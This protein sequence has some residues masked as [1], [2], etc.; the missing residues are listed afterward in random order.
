MAQKLIVFWKLHSMSK[1]VAKKAACEGGKTY[2]VTPQR[3][4]FPV[5]KIPQEA[6]LEIMKE[7]GERPEV[8]PFR[9]MMVEHT[10]AEIT[11]WKIASTFEQPK[12]KIEKY[13]EGT[14]L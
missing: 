11:S 4:E 2:T 6:I 9:G 8:N 14:L 1:D 12:T 3:S 5:D 10:F 7:H 13:E